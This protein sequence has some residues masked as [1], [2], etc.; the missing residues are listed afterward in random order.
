MSSQTLKDKTIKGVGWSAV[1]QVS[2][3]GIT[4]LVSLVL[5]R[6]L[7]PD[8][9]GLIGIITIFISVFNIF[10]ISGF[11]AALIR[12]KNANDRDFNTVFWFNMAVS[13]VLFGVL[14]FIAPSIADFFERVELTALIRI[15]GVLLLINAFAL[16]QTTIL[17]KQIDFK[18]QT[19]V[20]LIASISSGTIGIGMALCGLGVWSL[21]GQQ[22]SR[23]GFN[24]LF[25]WIWSKWRPRLEFSTTSFKELWGFGWKLL[26]SGLLNTIWGEM[27]Q[28]I[29]GKFYAPATLGQYARAHQFARVFSSNLTTI[30]QRV[31]YPVLSSIQDDRERLKEGYRKVIKSTMLVTFICMLMLAAIAKPMVLVLIG[32]KWLPCVVFLQLICFSMMLYPLHALNLNMLEVQGRSDLF[33]KLEIIKKV[34]A[35]GPICLGIFYSI[36]AMV[37]ASVFVGFISYYLNAYYSGPFLHYGIRHQIR[38]IQPSFFVAVGIALPVYLLSFLPFSPFLLLPLQLFVGAVL[39]VVLCETT[40]LPEYLEIRE[41]ILKVIRK[42]RKE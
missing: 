14:W 12:K 22:I 6:L 7:S 5:A 4:F 40:K 24:S 29:V 38:D 3:Q 41:I 19:K 2:N 32:E 10:I 9:Y 15:M 42:F 35:I 1:D 11:N 28:V 13:I 25:L 17:T 18:K 8:E 30:V 34:I 20:S 21:V 37:M 36:Y 31:S 26:V 27:Y 33:L 23:Q 39:A 16:I